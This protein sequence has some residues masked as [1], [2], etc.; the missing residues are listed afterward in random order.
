MGTSECS[1]TSFDSVSDLYDRFRPLYPDSLFADLVASSGIDSDSRVLEIGG[2][3]GI[4]TIPMV[5]RGFTLICLEPGPRLAT[6]LRSKVVG[7]PRTIVLE[8]TFEG[9]NDHG[10]AF[11]LVYSAQAFH[12]LDPA[13]RFQKVASVLKPGGWLAI[14]GHLPSVSS[15]Q[16]RGA[17]DDAYAHHAPTIA[18]RSPMSWYALDGPIRGLFAESGV[19]EEIVAHDHRWSTIYRTEEYLGLLQTMSEHQLLPPSR[20][21]ALLEAIARIL[22][23]NGKGSI[24]IDYESNLFMAR[25]IGR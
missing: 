3:T 1:A 21:D 20:R 5:E 6:I 7:H 18:G 24:T 4:A 8:T 17:L 19:F 11:D 25:R 14:F 15:P 9:W 12:W 13:I 10:S 16:V 23:T 2:G 22:E